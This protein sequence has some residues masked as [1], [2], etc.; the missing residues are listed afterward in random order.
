MPPVLSIIVPAYNAENYISQC[1]DSVINVVPKSGLVEIVVINDGSTDNTAKILMNYVN[2]DFVKIITQDNSGVSVARNIGIEVSTG[3]YIGFLDADDYWEFVSWEQLMEFIQLDVDIIEF[4]IRR[5]NEDGSFVE[6]VKEP[7]C[8]E[9]SIKVITKPLLNIIAIEGQWS[10]STR[11]FNRRIWNGYL[12]PE[13]YYEDLRLLPIIYASSNTLLATSINLVCY[14]K[15]DSSRTQTPTI[16]HATDVLMA[17]DMFFDLSQ[18]QHVSF[19]EICARKTYGVAVRI[20][21][22]IETEQITPHF[23]FLLDCF[24]KKAWYLF[25]TLDFRFLRYFLFPKLSFIFSRRKYIRSKSMTKKS[26]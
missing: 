21:S 23:W 20:A 4:K 18:Q 14:R 8:I 12:F 16:K 2:V 26:P 6:S 17:A 15:N 11:F 3:T 22:H 19:Y 24:R 10:F 1:L 5:V 25:F 9:S 7:G 13:G